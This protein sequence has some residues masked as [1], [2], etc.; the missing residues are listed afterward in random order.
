MPEQDQKDKNLK[1][2]LKK[3]ITTPN[4]KPMV[5]MALEHISGNGLHGNVGNKTGFM[6]QVQARTFP[7]QVPCFLSVFRGEPGFYSEMKGRPLEQS[8][9]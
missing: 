1:L 4:H 6:A 9:G 7:A 5:T 8:P 2:K 3:E